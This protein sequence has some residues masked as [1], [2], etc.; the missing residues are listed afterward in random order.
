VADPLYRRIADDLQAQ[1]VAGQLAPGSQLPPEAK[2]GKLFNASRNTI[3]DAIK[4][5]IALGLAETRAGQ[6][7][8]VVDPPD[9]L[10]TTLT[11]KSRARAAGRARPTSAK[12]ASVTLV[13]T[14]PPWNFRPHSARSRT[15]WG[16]QRARRW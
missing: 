9:P 7:T 16:F 5:L 8:L 3:R 2:L 13:A 15:G 4:F 14:S 11:T 12:P 1:I 6:G 10:V